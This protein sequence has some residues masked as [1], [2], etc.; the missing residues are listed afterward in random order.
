MSSFH[1]DLTIAGVTIR[2]ETEHPLPPEEAFL[3][4]AG[5]VQAPKYTA[6]FRQV[7][8]LPDI[9]P[10]V[11]WEGNCDRVHPDGAGGYVRS[12]FDAPRSYEPY[13]LG[14]YDYPGGQ[15]SIDYRKEGSLCV[16][17]LSTCF[18]HLGIEEL[19]LHEE[20]FCLHA[21]F[22]ETPLGGLLFSGP[23]GIGKS[24][25][26]ELWCRYRD[27]QQING[28]RP[29]LG[30]KNGVWTAWGSPYAGS[31]RCYVNRSYPVRAVIMLAQEK[32]C[33]LRRLSP[34]EAFRKIY[35]G[36][37]VHSWDPGFTGAALD[38]AAGFSAE[39]PVY[40]FGC[41]PDEAAVDY[42]DAALRREPV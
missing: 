24:T 29:I 33:R 2:L 27:S 40:E 36:L 37:T 12:F 1:C 20:K 35:Q 15:I 6:R 11:L 14:T 4:F 25:Q 16:S 26:A 13:A 41:T 10:Q 32:A 42:L 19:L 21:S 34:G 3:P 5:A 30:R 28:D 23:S 31:S 39:I 18:Y 17:E 22:V 8:K 38:F 9:P 7:D